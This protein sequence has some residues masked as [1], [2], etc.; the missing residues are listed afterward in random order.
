MNKFARP[1]LPL[2]A[3]ILIHS[4]S[5]ECSWLGALDRLIQAAL[6]YLALLLWDNSGDHQDDICIQQGSLSGTTGEPK[7]GH[8]YPVRD[9]V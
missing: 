6:A 8:K 7:S 1:L 4:S 3:I 2:V 9:T 5:T